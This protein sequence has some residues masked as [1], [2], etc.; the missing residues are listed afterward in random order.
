MTHALDDRALRTVP[1]LAAAATFLFHLVANPHYGF[2]RDE[3]YFIICGFHP[4]WGYVDQPPLVPLMSAATQLFGH[5]LVLLRAVPA[6]FA[7]AA[8]FT[9][10]RLVSEFGGRVFAQSLAAVVVLFTGVSAAFGGKVGTDEVGLWTW[11]LIAL[12]LVRL[13]KGVDPRW[14]LAAGVAAGVSLESKYSVIFFLA[15]ILAGLLLTP[16]RRVLFTRWFALGCAVAV[17]IA[18]PNFVWQWQHGFPMLEL[19]QNGQ[20]GKNIIVSPLFFL[21]QEIVITTPILVPVWMIGLGW[22]LRTAD[23]RF[24]GYAYVILIAEMIVLHG[25]HYYPA[26]VYPI[27][28]AAGAVPLEAWTR[29]LRIARAAMVAYAVVFG[30]AFVPFALPVLPED[31]FVAYEAKLNALLHLRGALATEHERETSKLP[32]DWADM[33]GWPELAATVKGVYDGLPPQERAQAVVFA[34]NYGS[35]AAIEFFTPDVPVI[36]IHNQYWVWGT[37]GYNGNVLVQVG[38]SC[39][40]KQHLF[41]SRTVVTTFNSRW[42]IGWEQHLPIAICRGIRTPLA[43]VWKTV[44]AFE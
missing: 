34:D 42:G 40:A 36:S 6:L 11:P 10:C 19:L 25:K 3:L 44:H 2:F 24:L 29:R 27:L 31:T 30:L 28:I 12:I 14:W 4:D 35:A 17:L 33:H 32:G 22:L 20:N 43:E 41:A 38:G 21:V 5:S 8:A 37:K 9:T 23:F 39:F 16:A 1:W 7:A 18:L 15:A 26:A 13:S